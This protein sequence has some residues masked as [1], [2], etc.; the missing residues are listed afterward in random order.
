MIFGLPAYALTKEEGDK[1]IRNIF[2]PFFGAIGVHEI[3]PS[4]VA[5]LPTK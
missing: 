3:L 2:R 4:E 1:L 5:K